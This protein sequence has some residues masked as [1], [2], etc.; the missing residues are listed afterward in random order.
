[1]LTCD[2][3]PRGMQVPLQHGSLKPS[4]GVLAGIQNAWGL[5][6]AMAAAYPAN[7]RRSTI[8]NCMVVGVVGDDLLGCC[9]YRLM[10]L[11]YHR[12][13]FNSSYRTALQAVVWLHG[14]L[15]GTAQRIA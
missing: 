10:R 13:I 3:E 14:I 4:Q 15:S 6:L 11:L 1:M 12:V 8:E 9:W 5:G 7:V 2:V